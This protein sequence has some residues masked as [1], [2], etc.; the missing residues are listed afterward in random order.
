MNGI[1]GQNSSCQGTGVYRMLTIIITVSLCLA[2]GQAWSADAAKKP[3]NSLDPK[4]VESL[5]QQRLSVAPEGTFSQF[6]NMFIV[7]SSIDLGRTVGLIGL[8]REVAGSGLQPVFPEFYSPTLRE[9]LDAIALQ[10]S[11][12]WKNDRSGRHVKNNA[13]S[14]APSNITIFEFAPVKRE[15]PYQIKL[16]KGWMGLDRGHWVMY[17]PPDFPVGMDIY[18]LGTYSF[19]S[20]QPGNMEKVRDEM[21]LQWGR[22]VQKGV[23]L[24]DMKHV[25]VGAYDALFF[26]TV[27]SA[28]NGKKVCW[29][30]WVFTAD[31][32]CYFVV[33]TI[34]PEYEKRIYPDVVAMLKS[35]QIKN[36]SKKDQNK[37]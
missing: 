8:T 23:E 10:S 31:N 36:S 33:S 34:F 22:R 7:Q 27:I 6:S 19:D 30:Q 18:Q 11:S 2:A 3:D 9:L 24:K 14:N 25:K 16:S 32:A 12:E 37:K 1:V 15:K 29:R 21:A 5:L 17:S 20:Q 35:F 4:Q 26:E 28:A 13:G